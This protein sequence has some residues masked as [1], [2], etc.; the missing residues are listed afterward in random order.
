MSSFGGKTLVCSVRRGA[1]ILKR[2]VSAARDGVL[3]RATPLLQRAR[4]AAHHGAER[5]RAMALNSYRHLASGIAALAALLVPVFDRERIVGAVG[6]GGAILKQSASAARDGVLARATPL[7]QR[8]RPAAH[9]GVERVRAISLSSYRHLASGIAALA[10]LVAPVFDRET[11]V[12]SVGRGG[13]TLKQ[14][15]LAARDGVLARAT[16]LQ[17]RARAAGHHGA[18]RALAL[19]KSYRYLATPGLAASAV[20]VPVAIVLYQSFLTAPLLQPNAQ[21]GLGAYRLVFGDPAFW[22][23]LGTTMLLASGMTAIA[24]PLGAGFAFLVARTDLPGRAWLEP[25]TLFP[26]F[27]PA[28]VLAFGY[29]AA[30]A[31]LGF[32]S[33]AVRE[34]IGVAPWSVYSLPSLIVLAGLIHV[35]HV[36]LFTAVALRALDG[37]IEDAART[38]GA[39]PWNVAVDVSLPMVLPA[40][41]S[42]GTLVFLLGFELFGLPLV[43][44]NAAGD[45]QGPLVLSTYLYS[46]AGKLGGPSFQLMAVVAV[47]MLAIA[48]PLLIVQTMLLR[49]AGRPGCPRCNALPSA[50]LRLGIARWPAFLVVV[51]WL[52]IV[53]IVPLTG[54]ILR[55]LAGN[56][57]DGF[58]LPLAF[59]L[60]HY[61][62]LLERPDVVR[63]VINT[64]GIGLVGGAVALAC[65]AAVAF[66]VSGRPSRRAGALG[67]LM[68]ASRVMPGLV[69]GLALLLLFL[70]MESLI[71]LAQTPISIWLAYTIVWL[72]VGVQLLAGT[73]RNIAPVLEEAARTVGANA[74]RVRLDITI[75]LIRSGMLTAWLLIVLIFVR[76]YSPAIFLLAPG[77]EV[78]GSLLVS[79]WQ[80]GATDL[81]FALSVVDV[82]LLSIAFS[83]AVRLGVHP[84]G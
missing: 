82:V 35:P 34:L 28:L 50:P 75:P 12:R 30:L 5:V 66:A 78:I 26:L 70:L 68:T 16:P 58:A 24:V 56:W 25:L 17:Q 81:V 37:E 83:I 77:S 42:A 61:R 52:L 64:L 62:S 38:A 13:A 53:L 10:V 48:T 51:L 3:A 7:L 32:L 73:L 74:T 27:V 72:A 18:E 44:G 19:F 49:Q 14:S 40:I 80:A 36:Y 2:S 46:L 39:G 31:P 54:I 21:F 4:P 20:L 11:I 1:A 9:H 65:Y 55:S 43:L 57:G 79:L 63:S 22:T 76:E 23:A 67:P 59:T 6:R 71:P 60:D 33:R 29:V 47:V 15:A 41:L 45:V 69:A 84:N 8:A